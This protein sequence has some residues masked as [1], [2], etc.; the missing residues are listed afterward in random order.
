MKLEN[1]KF[2]ELTKQF[3]RERKVPPD[4]RKSICQKVTE[5]SK[6]RAAVVRAMIGQDKEIKGFTFD[7]KWKEFINEFPR[8]DFTLND[9][10][11]YLF[12]FDPK[13]SGLPNLK[14]L[15]QD[16]CNWQGPY[17]RSRIAP[18]TFLHYHYCAKTNGTVTGTIDLSNSVSKSRGDQLG[19]QLLG[20]ENI[21]VSVQ[22][23][24]SFASRSSVGLELSGSPRV[25]L[26]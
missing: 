25:F 8:W 21:C 18:I 26:E 3:L 15:R 9:D 5:G 23:K 10:D 20:T 19:E 11:N 17:F 12:W 16:F 7:N 24:R 13:Y 14:I 22:P 1:T 2:S 6:V 4:H